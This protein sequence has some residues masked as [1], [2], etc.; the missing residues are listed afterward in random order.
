MLIVF[1]GLPASGKSTLAAKV[2]AELGGVYLRIDSIEQAMKD[3]GQTV[4]GPE[5][6]LVARALAEDNLRH[7]Q[8]VVVD[9]VNPNELTRD[10]WR[11]LA[12]RLHALLV[13]IHVV[14]SDELEHEKRVELR[15]PDIP[16]HKLPNWQQVQDRQFEP[17]DGAMVV[18]T[19]NQSASESVL[20]TT[21]HLSSRGLDR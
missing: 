17:W 19:A 21:S 4:S 18:D 11:N 5:G 7:D 6:Y 20:E 8:H 9:A 1:G 15:T 14:C 13:E 10:Y 3:S 16:G 12:K 2:A